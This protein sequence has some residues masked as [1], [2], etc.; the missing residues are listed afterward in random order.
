[1]IGIIDYGLGNLKS[2]QSA[3]EK[4]S[5]S[6]IMI[7]NTNDFSKAKKYILPGVGSFNTGMKNLIKLN[8][9]RLI[10]KKC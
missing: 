6:Y 7:R 3:L 9:D 1:M 10:K 8:Y 4:L 2:I 5:A